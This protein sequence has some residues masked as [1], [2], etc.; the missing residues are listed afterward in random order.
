[1]DE[2]TARTIRFLTATTGI[3]ILLFLTTFSMIV[4]RNR[5]I[6]KLNSEIIQLRADV[7]ACNGVI[8][9]MSPKTHPV[10]DGE[11]MHSIEL[12][13]KGTDGRNCMEWQIGKK[14]ID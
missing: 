1:M 9:K 4:S 2:D 3:L 13:D 12:R 11:V 6:T 8:K 10:C 14:E 5:E 7:K